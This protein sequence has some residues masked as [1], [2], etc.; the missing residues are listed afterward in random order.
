MGGRAVQVEVIFLHVLAMI[1]FVAGK[2]ED[3]FF[4]D[5]IALIPQRHSKTDHL[6]PVAD[7]G[8]TVFVPPL[9]ARTGVVMRQIF[10][11]ISAGAIVFPHGAT[12]PFAALG[13]PTLPGHLARAVV[14]H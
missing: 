13:A 1:A 6:S 8:P 4:Q 9:S 7:A 5:G 12:G 11:R 2:A 3:P 14:W 10:P